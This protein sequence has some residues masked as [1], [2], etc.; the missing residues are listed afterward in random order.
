MLMMLIV[1]CMENRIVV[2]RFG[3][4]GPN[5][6]LNRDVKDGLVDQDP[7]VE[8]LMIVNHNL[9]VLVLVHALLHVLPVV[10]ALQFLLEIVQFLPFDHPKCLIMKFEEFLTP[11]HLNTL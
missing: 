9:I 8:M 3:L 1:V 2:G 5:G 11:H 6:D 7:P 4:N 10:L